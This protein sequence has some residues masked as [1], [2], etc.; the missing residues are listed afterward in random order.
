MIHNMYNDKANEYL[1]YL[2]S[3]FAKYKYESIFHKRNS[4]TG[5][6]II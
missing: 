5:L 2:K 6:Q 4:N 3:L 1:Q